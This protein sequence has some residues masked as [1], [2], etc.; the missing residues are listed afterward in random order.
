M[1]TLTFLLVFGVLVLNIK[2]QYTTPVQWQKCL[3][4]TDWEDAKSIKQT[5]DGGYIIAGRSQ[6]NDGDVTGHHSTFMFYDY[7]IAKIDSL[8]NIQ[9]QKSLGGSVTDEANSIQQTND[10]GYI[11]AGVSGSNDGDVTG[12]HGDVDFWVV[13]L[14]TIGNIIWQKSLGGTGFDY[15]T[16]IQQT[17]DG[18]YIVAGES[19]S[20]DGD[21]TGH[22]GSTGCYQSDMDYWVVKLDSTGNIIWQK[23]LGGTDC[24][25]ASSIQQTNDGGY[26]IAGVSGSNDGDVSG[27]HGFTINN[28]GWFD[29]WIIK[30]DSAGNIQWQKSYGGTNDDQAYSIQQSNEGGYIIAGW[31][32]SNDGDVTGHHGAIGNAL[33]DYWVVKLDSTGNIQWQKSLGGT[34]GDQAT[35][36]QQTNDGGY[37]VAGNSGSNDG[38]VTGNH[39]NSD[40]WIVKLDSTG[41]I[42]WQKCLGGS[43]SESA[44]SIQQ[45]IDGGYIV[46]GFT[47]SNDGDVTGLHGSIYSYD[48]WIVKLCITTVTAI[49]EQNI[50]SNISIYPNPSNSNFTIKVTPKTR[51][52]QISN[53]LGQVIERRLVANQKE[54]YFEIK[55]TGIYFVQIITDKETITKKVIITN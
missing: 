7:W 35:S 23:S 25:C 22:H 29:Y 34:D 19:G 37:I 45:A 42:Q 41:S 11:V 43:F 49:D 17:N 15:A 32:D 20:N 3:G 1:K 47:Q 21:V 27:H 31:S 26:I 30:L 40:F 55:E 18:G 53:F 5:N 39:G 38:D 48:Y 12:N 8:G 33:Y 36:I 2:A 9:W 51:Y 13:K 46:G 44:N 50:S 4:G 54:L 16:S 28:N 6:S 10:G 52:I 14:D 24:D